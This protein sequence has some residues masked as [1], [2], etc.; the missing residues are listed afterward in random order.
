MKAKSR[1]VKLLRSRGFIEPRQHTVNFVGML[2]TDFAPVIVKTFQAAM[3][4]MP[5]H[6]AMVN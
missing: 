3:P 4:K 1:K 6:R 5:Y 2:L